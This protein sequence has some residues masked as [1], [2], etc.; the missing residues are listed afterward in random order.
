MFNR[1]TLFILGAGASA[2]VDIPI[3]TKL[4]STIGKK[5]DI[6]FGMGNE[7]IG[8]GDLDL[9]SHIKQKFGQEVREYQ[10]AGWLIRDGITLSQSIDDF[11]DLHRNNQWINRYGKV[12]IVKAVLEAERT[13]KLYFDGSSGT[14]T[15]NSDR[16]ADTWFVKFM[17]MLGRGIPKE[18]AREIF[19]RV[20]F[21]IFNYDRCVEHFL[22][23]SLQK[24]YGI[25]E[26]EASEI[27]GDLH[28]IHPYGVIGDLEQR[29]RP[30]GIP[31]GN[32][33]RF[34]AD[35]V[36]LSDRIKTYTE[37]IAAGEL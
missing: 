4:A 9:Y 15:L 29:T 18:N 30:E 22:S 33:D 7:H 10:R 3:G 20:S 12:A 16:V 32:G 35:Y 21:I 13:S 34:S 6:R 31:F 1:Q 5:M 36:A 17:H 25:P 24:L 2:E 23:N 28:I 19:D 14:E 37:K 27:L 11:L 8:T 26:Q